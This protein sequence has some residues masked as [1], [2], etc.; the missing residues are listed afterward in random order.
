MRNPQLSTPKTQLLVK[1]FDVCDYSLMSVTEAAP[2]LRPPAHVVIA[3]TVKTLL[4][5]SD[6]EQTDLAEFLH[7]EASTISRM[8]NGKRKITVD[9]VALLAEFFG[10]SVQL[11]FDGLDGV[12]D[13][14]SKC[15]SVLTLVMGD[16]DGHLFDPDTLEIPS[17][18]RRHLTVV[19]S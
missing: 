17:P 5:H 16:G 18:E 15:S 4:K 8:L 3:H 13:I 14:R 9:E 1:S 11:L 6:R 19:R 2:I 12:L 7:Y 10:C